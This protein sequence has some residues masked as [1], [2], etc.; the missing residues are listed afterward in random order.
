MSPGSTIGDHR[1]RHAADLPRLAMP[2]EAWHSTCTL[3][4][5]ADNDRPATEWPSGDHAALRTY[6]GGQ[7]GI[8]DGVAALDQRATF[9]RMDSMLRATAGNDDALPTRPR[10]LSPYRH[11]VHHRF[12]AP[13]DLGEVHRQVDAGRERYGR[14]GPRTTPSRSAVPPR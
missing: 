12:C 7:P 2:G 14:R 5:H 1:L 11:P 8:P 13:L 9:A 4:G 6:G 10:V 3:P